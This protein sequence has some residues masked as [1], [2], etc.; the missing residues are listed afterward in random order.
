MHQNMNIGV[1][2]GMISGEQLARHRATHPKE[3]LP[4]RCVGLA[5]AVL[6]GRLIE[7]ALLDRR[8]GWF[9]EANGAIARDMAE[10]TLLE[11]LAAEAIDTVLGLFRQP[12]SFV[13]R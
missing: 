4:P 9:V 10:W 6:E 1:A 13:I 3:A 7:S 2:M 12:E 8:L 5:A 11:R